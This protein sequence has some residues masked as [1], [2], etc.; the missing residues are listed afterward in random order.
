V[1]TWLATA[2]RMQYAHSQGYRYGWMTAFFQPQTWRDSGQ[3]E[4]LVKRLMN[5]LVL[6]GSPYQRAVMSMAYLSAAPPATPNVPL[7]GQTD[8]MDLLCSRPVSPPGTLPSFTSSLQSLMVAR[9]TPASW[10]IYRVSVVPAWLP[11]G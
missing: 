6:A 7:K 11:Y 2:V 4:R 8:Q 10:Q 9:W 5:A 3:A 1:E